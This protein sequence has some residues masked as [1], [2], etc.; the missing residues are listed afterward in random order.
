MEGEGGGDSP[1]KHGEEDLSRRMAPA[2]S[3]SMHLSSVGDGSALKGGVLRRGGSGVRDV[4]S[5]FISLRGF[6]P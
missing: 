3:M 1:L 2:T 6:V 4:Y 5:A